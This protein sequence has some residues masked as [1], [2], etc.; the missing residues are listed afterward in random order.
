MKAISIRN[1]HANLLVYGPKDIETRNWKTYYR[2]PI[3]IHVS[4]TVCY[5]SLII[6]LEQERFKKLNKAKRLDQPTGVILA[7][8]QLEGIREYTSQEAFDSDYDRHLLNS[9]HYEVTKFGWIISNIIPFIK[10]IPYK[11]RQGLFD[12]DISLDNLIKKPEKQ[13]TL[14]DLKEPKCL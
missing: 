4:K 12:A 1:P 14:D 13:L 8:G 3:L 6:F 5:D 11:G 10:P 7:K 2:G 9:K